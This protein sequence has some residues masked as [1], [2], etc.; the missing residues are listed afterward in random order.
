MAFGYYCTNDEEYRHLCSLWTKLLW[1]MDEEEIARWEEISQVTSDWLDG[2]P[3][4]MPTTT[5][6][7]THA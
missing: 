5:K 7:V 4:P 2:H 6:G 1:S 3:T